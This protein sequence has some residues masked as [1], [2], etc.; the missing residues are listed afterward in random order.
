MTSLVFIHSPT[1]REVSK[2]SRT[3]RGLA[4]A[5]FFG[6]S[7]ASR[8]FAVSAAP[9]ALVTNCRRLSSC[10]IGGSSRPGD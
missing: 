5:S 6:A 7:A 3:M 2:S 8:A 10:V 1:S 9:A 4:G